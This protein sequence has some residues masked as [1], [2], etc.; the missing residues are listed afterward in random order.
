MGHIHRDFLLQTRTARRLYR[1][2]TEA[3]PILDY[4]CH[5]PPK[6]IAEIRPLKGPLFEITHGSSIT[7]ERLQLPAPT[8]LL[9]RVCGPN[10]RDI[11]IR[12]ADLMKVARVV[13]LGADAEADAVEIEAQ[14]SKR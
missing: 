11:R 12:Q 2:S 3:A 5:L 14:L 8:Q 6:D 13:E 7:L 1:D 4:H 10:A 9:L